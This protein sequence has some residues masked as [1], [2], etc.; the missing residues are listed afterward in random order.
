MLPLGQLSV[1]SD[2]ST[3]RGEPAVSMLFCKREKKVLKNFAIN[4]CVFILIGIILHK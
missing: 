3:V 1:I 4:G 2:L